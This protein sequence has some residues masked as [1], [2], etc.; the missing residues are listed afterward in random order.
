MLSIAG[1]EI[2]LLNESKDWLFNSF[3]KFS[4]I[5]LF[6]V[7][8][9]LVFI[10]TS[11]MSNDWLSFDWFDNYY[12]AFLLRMMMTCIYLGLFNAFVLKFWIFWFGEGSVIFKLEELDILLEIFYADLFW[13][14]L[15]SNIISTKL[16]CNSYLCYP[17]RLGKSRIS[18]FL[19]LL[20]EM[21]WL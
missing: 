8:V 11:F 1:A 20:E 4:G 21:S 6:G 15:R 19:G 16:V 9:W 14:V 12:V 7:D 10:C 17:I 3:G 5:F 18:L 2:V 13:K